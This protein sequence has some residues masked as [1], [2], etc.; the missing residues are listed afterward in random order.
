MNGGSV[1][2]PESIC[3]MIESAGHLDG[4]TLSGGD[5]FYQ[6]AAAAAIARFC[7]EHGLNVWCYTGFTYE[8]ILAG[9]APGG[10]LELL[11]E[12]DVLVDGP[13]REELKSEECLYRGS[14]NQRLIDLDCCRKAS[15]RVCLYD[16]D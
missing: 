12:V 9:I 13:F 10:A 15:G 3:S 14:S 4:V 1:T 5:P 8:D 16:P 2:D 7:H 6:P 11:N